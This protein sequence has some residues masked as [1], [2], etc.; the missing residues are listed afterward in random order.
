MTLFPRIWVMPNNRPGDDAQV[1]ALAEELRLPFETRKLVYNWRFWLGGRYM[2][3]S[4]ISVE[5]ELRERTL[6][7]PW[8]DLIILVGR[9]AVPVARWVQKQNGG[10]TRLVLV[11]HPRVTPDYFDLVFTTRQYCTPAGASMR[12]LPVA[13]SRYRQP[14]KPSKEEDG[15]LASLPRPHLLLMLGGKTRHWQMRPRSI[16]DKAAQLARRAQDAGGSLIV[17]RSARTSE[18][19]LEAI[20]ERLDHSGCEWRVVRHDFPRFA[21]L[22]Q[23]A[24]ELFPTADSISMISESI[25]TGKPVGVVPAEMNWVGWLALGARVRERNR[26]RDLRRFWNY[27][28]GEGLAGTMEEPLASSTPNPVTAA[29]REVRALLESS[30]GKLPE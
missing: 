10:K 15:W 2:G 29:A 1:Y 14:V 28:I 7:P 30:F 11:G 27:V 20:E 9:R 3:A 18:E 16:A 6:V 5:K 26:K 23:D 8:P 13:M 12:E 17:A 4:P 21:A 22:L 19:I 25:I 24:D